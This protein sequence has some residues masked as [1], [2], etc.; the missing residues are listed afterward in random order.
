MRPN[1][2]LFVLLLSVLNPPLGWYLA[3]KDLKAMDAGEMD[4]AGRDETQLGRSIAR[5]WVALILYCVAVFVVCCAL[6]FLVVLAAIVW[7]LL[8]PG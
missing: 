7:N 8:H 6:V 4:P 3:D 1:R 5:W 2:G